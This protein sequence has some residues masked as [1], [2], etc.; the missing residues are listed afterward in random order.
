MQSNEVR[1]PKGEFDFSPTA[2]PCQY[3]KSSFAKSLS[4]C[5]TQT[6]SLDL[7]IN[8]NLQEFDNVTEIKVT[9][10]PSL[11]FQ[12]RST[13][14][15]AAG[16]I[17]AAR[18]LLFPLDNNNH[19]PEQGTKM[20]NGSGDDINGNCNANKRVCKESGEEVDDDKTPTVEQLQNNV[21]SNNTSNNNQKNIN[22]E[23]VTIIQVRKKSRS[24]SFGTVRSLPGTG[25][26]GSLSLF[27]YPIFFRPA[28]NDRKFPN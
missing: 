3:F 26:N 22:N 7:E 8:F 10:P 13:S 20:C 14:K 24:L 6:K 15:G 2:Q 9:S 23:S 25:I 18:S 11:D 28:V 27:D 17:K 16:A 21:W 4:F 12:T 19:S 1:I 5:S